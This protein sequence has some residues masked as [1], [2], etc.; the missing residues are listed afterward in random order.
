MAGAS[1]PSTRG[2]AAGRRG[3]APILR[4][5]GLLGWSS[6][7]L[8]EGGRLVMESG[9]GRHRPVASR[10]DPPARVPCT[11]LPLCD[12]RSTGAPIVCRLFSRLLV[13]ALVQ[14]PCR[15][16]GPRRS[17][18]GVL[19]VELWFSWKSLEQLL[20]SPRPLRFWSLPEHFALAEH[21]FCP[22]LRTLTWRKTV[23][24]SQQGKPRHQLLGS[25]CRARG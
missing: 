13:W 3:G 4:P 2:R 15:C 12:S 18:A 10:R 16:E 9:R 25:E 22:R 11:V 19:A 5:V 23:R 8:E 17:G 7:R 1:R 20:S 24:R 21:A 6:L 14:R